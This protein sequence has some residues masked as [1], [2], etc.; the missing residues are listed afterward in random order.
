M[1]IKDLRNTL[2][3]G[4]STNDPFLREAR[5]LRSAAFI[6]VITDGPIGIGETYGGFS[7]AAGSSTACPEGAEGLKDDQ[8]IG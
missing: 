4:P 1:R 8:A 7:P 2:L 5:K 3:T 6:E